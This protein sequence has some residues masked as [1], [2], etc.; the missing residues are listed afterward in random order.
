MA[1][2]VPEDRPSRSF[3]RGSAPPRRRKLI[4]GGAVAALALALALGP[5]RGLNPPG[6]FT[7]YTEAAAHPDPS[8]DRDYSPLYLSFVRTLY[9]VGGAV[10]VRATQAAAFTAVAIAIWFAVGAEAGWR[11]GLLAG[12]AAASYR[13]FLTYVAV[14]EP[15]NLLLFL[16]AVAVAAGV[17]ARRA[18]GGWG[19]G[20]VRWP[21]AAAPIALAMAS[22]ALAGAIRPQYLALVP[23]WSVW[24]GMAGG[25]RWPRVAAGTAVAAALVLAPVLGRQLARFGTLTVMD[26][27]TVLYEGNG[28]QSS[29]GVYSPPLVVKALERQSGEADSAHVEYRRVASAAAGAPLSSGEVNRFWIRL[30]VEGMR[31][32][33]VA[34][35][36]RLLSKCLL[37]VAPYEIHDLANAADLDRKLRRWIPWGFLPLLVGL[38]MV[39]PELPARWRTVLG[40]LAVI[41]LVWAVQIVFYPSARYRLPLALGAL[42][43]GPTLAAGAK[44]RRLRTAA[45]LA[46]AGSILVTWVAAPVA[47][48]H[49]AVVSSWLGPTRSGPGERA[50][51]LLDGRSWRPEVGRLA[52]AL[53]LLGERGWP[54]ESVRWAGLLRRHGDCA[55]GVPDWMCGRAAYGMARISV[56]Q[57]RR[58]EALR[59]AKL[60]AARAPGDAAAVALE[61]LLAAGRCPDRWEDA[62]RVPGISEQEMRFAV[63]RESLQLYG[64]ACA[65]GMAGPLIETFP[66]LAGVL[67]IAR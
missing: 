12:L 30:A 18:L 15:E 66:E 41:A 54:P 21:R 24:I 9:P 29:A 45:G 58:D 5:A 27:G 50:A 14:L 64:P 22:V 23:V 26:P 43:V 13:P 6:S 38:L 10:L 11:W 60:A 47:A 52:D 42:V 37:A 62:W 56:G 55:G 8:R 31:D 51:A 1:V 4:A 63:A 53:V 57:G 67:S 33:P 65:R 44:A 61:R 3:H 48:E 39:V 32:A 36:R 49:E 28:P 20:A 40:P 35:G 19:R 16:L 7:K 59:W 2:K 46:L 17:G 25:K 34:A